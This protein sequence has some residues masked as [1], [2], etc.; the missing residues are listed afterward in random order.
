MPGNGVMNTEG[1]SSHRD[2]HQACWPV[3]PGVGE[4]GD[5]ARKNVPECSSVFQSALGNRTRKDANPRLQRTQKGV[6]SRACKCS[7]KRTRGPGSR[8]LA[9]GL[10]PQSRRAVLEEG[11]GCPQ[12]CPR[13]P[14]ATQTQAEEG[15][16]H[17]RPGP[18][19]TFNPP[20]NPCSPCSVPEGLPGGLGGHSWSPSFQGNTMEK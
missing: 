20:R 4:V 15:H 16:A 8:V 7:P 12:D 14:W 1:E 19:V 2:T 9:F 6:R 13:G 11:S 18:T 17:V 3:I 10:S 5:G